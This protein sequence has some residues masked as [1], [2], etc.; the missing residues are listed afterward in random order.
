MR[1]T[2]VLA[3]ALALG[4]IAAAPAFADCQSD[5]KS[6]EEATAKATDA[7]QKAEAQRHIDMAK[8]ELS[9]ANEKACSEHATAAKAALKPAY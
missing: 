7:K 8:S 1:K 9:K 4:G 6:A 3:C 2:I 5:I